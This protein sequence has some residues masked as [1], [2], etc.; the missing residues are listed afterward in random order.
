MKKQLSI[1]ALLILLN[2]LGIM[3]QKL[4]YSPAYPDL[5]EIT[6]P[7][8][9]KLK[10]RLYGDEFI[11][12]MQTLDGYTIIQ[13]K[14]GYYEY[15]I[16]SSDKSYLINSGIKANNLENR[17]N[18]E[19][20]FLSNTDKNIQRYLVGKKEVSLS[21]LSKEGVAMR[22]I[23]IT[24]TINNLV[25]LID[26]TDRA[27]IHQQVS[28]NNLMNQENYLGIGSYRDYYLDNSF[29]QLTIN[30]TIVGWFHAANS[31]E[32]Y[33][34]NDIYGNDIN[35]R[36]LVQEAI[37][38]AENA[39]LDFS[40]F[41]NDDDGKVDAVTVIH[42]GYGE[43]AG[44]G[45]NTI[46]SHRWNLG[47]YKRTYDGVEIN[48]YTIVPELF[49]NLGN[50]ITSIGVICH[51]FGHILGL[52]DLYDTD[53]GSEGVGEWDLMGSGSWNN[54]GRT[55]S[56]LSAW[57]KVFLGWQT[58]QVISS[59][60]K[61]DLLNSSQN[62]ISYRINTPHSN[63]YFL[64][65]N[66]QSIGFDAAL[67]GTGLC[68]WHINTNKTTSSHISANDVNADENLKGVD[69]EEADGN[70]DL[71]N[72][73]N[74]GD[75]GDL[76]P[77]AECNQTFNDNSNPNSRTYSPVVN[78]SKPITQIIEDNNIISFN[79]RGYGPILGANVVCTSGSTFTITNMPPG[80]TVN[81]TRSSNLSYVSGQGTDNYTVK[82]YS[83][84]SGTGWVQAAIS[85]NC[86]NVTIRYN[87]DWVGK[88]SPSI[89]GLS[90][91]ECGF[92]VWYFI[93]SESIHWGDFYWST[94]YMLRIIGTTTGH[95]AKIEGLEEGY[96]QIFCEVTNT[97][98]SAE[99]RLVV[100][101]EC[102]GFKMSPNPAD[103]YFELIIE[104]DET[105]LTESKYPDLYEVSIYNSTKVLVYQKTT[106]E[107]TLRINTRNLVNGTYYVN[108]TLGEKTKVKQL[109]VNH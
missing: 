87:I 54:L 90:E 71:D 80:T 78:T 67:P 95:K 43:E 62:N 46:W 30:S 92:P 72:Q 38:A 32:T 19:N 35:P 14:D 97:C 66:R 73:T 6:Y 70:N 18:V 69:L 27:F 56:N 9:S 23:P 83:S 102:W 65:E 12:F 101:I 109:V 75:D 24:G 86:G 63:E 16:L 2:C 10:T 74:R 91:L 53:G 26:F 22:S 58:P 82:A 45:S 85:G 28:F 100:W 79:Y 34:A 94:D 51:E 25:I 68:V 64:L 77:G 105:K 76:F 103:D 104:K 50:M 8:G 39:G 84:A 15:A 61:H 4:S 93:N 60:T 1:V 40:Q 29:D 106:K 108:I 98:G 36:L 47:S 59:P 3:G 55:P 33:G 81:W 21:E 7:D 49:G 37:D 57:C 11:H 89:I 88:P 42:A 52:P 13:N 48:E 107:P 5:I 31:M 44:A 17:T 20:T 96:G 41:D 99:N